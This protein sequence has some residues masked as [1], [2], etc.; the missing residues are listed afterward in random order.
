VFRPAAVTVEGVPA[1]RVS[2]NPVETG[3]LNIQF[4]KQVKGRYNI[5]LVDLTGRM[6]YATNKEHAGGSANQTIAL[7]SGIARGAYQLVITAPDRTKQVEKI[8]INTNN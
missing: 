1:I 6:V 3:M 7:P 8:I 2:P 5:R 4:T